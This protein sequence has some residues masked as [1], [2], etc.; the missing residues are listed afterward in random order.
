[1]NISVTYYVP[2]SQT[3]IQ[4]KVS[5][6]SP[7]EDK[8]HVSPCRVPTPWSNFS[9]HLS[10]HFVPKSVSAHLSVL[11][12]QWQKTTLSLYSEALQLSMSGPSKELPQ[13]PSWQILGGTREQQ[14][15]VWIGSKGRT[16][17]QLTS[18]DV[19][20]Y[21]FWTPVSMLNYHKYHWV[22]TTPDFI[23]STLTSLCPASCSPW[24]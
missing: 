14:K 11:H 8:C 1:M 2:C 18:N 17:L 15:R 22:S 20:T 24:V 9:S 4:R 21:T 13:M 6:R 19:T 5:S 23:C 7:L 16:M 3:Y 10:P 12:R